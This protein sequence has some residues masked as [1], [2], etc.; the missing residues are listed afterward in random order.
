VITIPIFKVQINADVVDKWLNMLKGY[1]LVHSFFDRD[2][3]T[4]AL[5][6]AAPHVKDLWEIYC[7]KRA[8]EHPL[9]LAAP[10]WSSF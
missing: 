4:F 10:T 7:E 9:F 8:E 1:F 6:K 2:K 3:I 5:L